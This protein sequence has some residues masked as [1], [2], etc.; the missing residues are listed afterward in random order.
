MIVVFLLLYS[1]LFIAL[2]S[3]PLWIP[4]D[5]A[6]DEMSHVFSEPYSLDGD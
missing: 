6:R 4:S 5:A 3:L 2:A 1:A